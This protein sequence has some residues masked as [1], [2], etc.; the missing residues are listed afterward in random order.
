MLKKATLRIPQPL[1]AKLREQSLREGRSL[2]QTAVR[3][4][5]RGLGGTVSAEDWL[6]L[7]SVIESAPTLPYDPTELRKLRAGLGPHARDLQDD[8]DL[9]RGEP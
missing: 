8:L 5:E 6:A 3:A 9:V 7:G 4:I 1:L 2:N